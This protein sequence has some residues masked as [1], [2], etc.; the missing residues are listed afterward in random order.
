MKITRISTLVVNAR[1]RNWVFVKVETDQGLVGWGEATL[2]WHT[3]AVVGAVADLG[4][5][6]AGMDPR[7]VE[8]LFQTGTRQPFWPKGLVGMSALSGIE[9]ACWDIAGKALDVPVF[10]LLGGR[11]REHVRLYDHL[12]GGEPGAMYLDDAPGHMA[13]RAVESVAA[14]FDAIKVMTVPRARPL[15]SEEVLRHCD[16]MMRAVREAVGPDV[17]IMVDFHGRTWPEQAIRFA[18]VLRPYAPL[19]IEEPVLPGDVPGLARVARAVSPIPVA[20]GERLVGRRDVR[21]VLEQAAVAVL[22]P[23]LCHTGGL[24]EGHKIAAMAETYNVS[25]AFHNPL[26][27]ISTAAAIHLAFA[28]PN[29]LIQEQLRAD[30][31]WRDEVCPVPF[32][33]RQGRALPMDRPGLGIEVDEDAAAAHPQQPEE[34]VRWWHEDGSVADW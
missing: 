29:F 31:P 23:D 7:R 2:E 5:F 1:L 16:E 17:D 26:G 9:Q 8:H 20:A 24:W 19:F 28:T 34:I 30:V 14:G 33:I 4:P 18:E 25:M 11:V 32:P 13:E 10:E 15:E 22:Q 6:L 27:P 21:P 3:Q 12:G